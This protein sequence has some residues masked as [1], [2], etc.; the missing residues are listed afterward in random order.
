MR[1]LKETPAVIKLRNFFKLIN[2]SFQ[3]ARELFHEFLAAVSIG[4]IIVFIVMLFKYFA[5]FPPLFAGAVIFYAYR[6]KKVQL[7]QT[8]QYHARISFMSFYILLFF[9]GFLMKSSDKTAFLLILLFPVEFFFIFWA[10]AFFKL[11]LLKE[12]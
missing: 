4:T 7:L 6:K 11:K 1:A 10:A 3:E 2:E 5:L 12:M 8:I 9:A